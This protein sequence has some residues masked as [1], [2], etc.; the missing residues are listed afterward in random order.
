MYDDTY[1]N[2]EISITRY[3]DGPEF[4][5]L[6]RQL[7]VNDGLSIRKASNNPILDTHIYEV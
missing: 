6:T 2:M 4:D 5:W 1:L 7:G 3:S